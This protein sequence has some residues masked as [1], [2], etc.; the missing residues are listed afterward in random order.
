MRAHQLIGEAAPSPDVLGVLFDAFD[1]AW[2]ELGP[3]VS[4][5]HAVVDAA[6]VCLAEIVLALAEV[7]PIDRDKIKSAAVEVFRQT[8]LIGNQSN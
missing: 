4:G 5:D 6:R 2:A 7:G 8:H 3:N 1:D